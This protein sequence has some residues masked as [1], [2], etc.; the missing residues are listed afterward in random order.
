MKKTKNNGKLGDLIAENDASRLAN[1]VH[2]L[3]KYYHDIAQR[4]TE[5][6]DRT[7]AQVRADIV[8]E[9]AHENECLRREL[10][11]SVACVHSDMELEAYNRFVEDHQKCQLNFKIDSGKMP[12]VVQ[13]GT[14][15]GV[16]TKVCCP[17]CGTVTDITDMSIW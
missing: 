10:K 13:V 17:I 11:Y 15:V 1:E 16:C 12:Y 8:N 6:A 14:G 3:I 4:A 2:D 9:F 5:R 7:E